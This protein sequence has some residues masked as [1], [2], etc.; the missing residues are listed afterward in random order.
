MSGM[1]KSTSDSEVGLATFYGGVRDK[2]AKSLIFEIAR[3]YK[4]SDSFQFVRNGP[5]FRNKK[6]IFELEIGI[7]VWM[8]CK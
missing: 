4:A 2:D 5:D 3:F 8:S 1:S 7:A 6:P